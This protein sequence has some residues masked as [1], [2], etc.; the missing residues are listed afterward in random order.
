MSNSYTIQSGDTL[1]GIAVEHNVLFDDILALNPEYQANPDKIFPGKTIRLP[2]EETLKHTEA[3]NQVPPPGILRGTCEKGAISSAPTC[4][5]EELVDIVFVLDDEHKPADFYCLTQKDK[6]LLLE[7]ETITQGFIKQLKE[8]NSKAPNP[9]TA[10]EEDVKQ[11]IL[12]RQA[13]LESVI[14]AGAVG[15]GEDTSSH[16]PQVASTGESTSEPSQVATTGESDTSGNKS[17][18]DKDEN[19]KQIESR[20]E[21][22]SQKIGFVDEYTHEFFQDKSGKIIGEKL[23]AELEDD[24]QYW[25]SLLDKAEKKSVSATKQKV[26]LNDFAHIRKKTLKPAATDHIK[27]IVVAGENRTIY[28]RPQFLLREK[29]KHWV[30]NTSDVGFKEALDALDPQKFKKKLQESL[31]QDLF[32]NKEIPKTL[33]ANLAKWEVEGWNWVAWEAHGYLN[34][35]DGKTV[36]ALSSSAQLFRWAAQASAGSKLELQDGVSADIGVGADASFSLAEAAVKTEAYVPYKQGWELSLTYQNEKKEDCRYS[37]GRF[38]FKAAIELSAFLGVT[39]SGNVGAA[40]TTDKKVEN[41]NPGTDI[42]IAPNVSI[43]PQRKTENTPGG[44]IGVKAGGF[45]GAQLG[46]QVT[47]A[48]EWLDPDDAPKLDFSALAQVSAEGNVAFGAGAGVDFQLAL[49]DNSKFYL[50]CSA[51]VVWGPGAKGGFATEIDGDKLFDSRIQLRSATLSN[52]KKLKPSP[53]I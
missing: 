10:T 14:N 50:H 4:V 19:K 13:W 49:I 18:L 39:A 48:V 37:F 20:I 24:Q 52:I 51:Q 36:F 32:K 5:A 16:Q 31:R 25:Q 40:A 33:K 30:S 45:A 46:G 2:E 22:I 47:G 44:N 12:D 43:E 28:V 26:D 29:D 35:S 9:E 27:E 1:L 34:N 23:L 21:E 42:I 41:P 6:D 7:E 38:R 17:G 11:H 53:Q 3:A 15:Y 8:L